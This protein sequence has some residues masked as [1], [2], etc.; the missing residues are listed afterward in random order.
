MKAIRQYKNLTIEIEARDQVELFEQLAAM[1]EVFG[2]L[3]AGA[4]IDGKEVTSSD[5]SFVVRTDN[6]DNNYYEVRCNSG[7][8]QWYK[9]RFGVHKT[10]K[11]LFPRS[12][13]G[14]NEIAGLRGWFKFVKD[15]AVRSDAGSDF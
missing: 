9:R 5:V 4:V 7:P 8:L 12:N 3:E 15:S 13:P 11:S 2:N 14:P 10:G 1:D 6:E